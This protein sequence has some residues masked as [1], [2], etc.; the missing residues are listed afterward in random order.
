MLARANTLWGN[1]A[2]VQNEFDR[3]FRRGFADATR[4]YYPPVN[5]AENDDA[6]TIEAR[7]PGLAASEVA[8]ELEGRQLT[9]RGEHKRDNA[10]YGR[11]ERASGKFE[12][13]FTF[14]HEL[15]A[16]RVNAEAKDGILTIVLP[17]AEEAKARKISITAK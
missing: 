12:R 15:A 13:K 3:F 6:Y 5:I 17:K 7:V 9:I 4:G 1:F 8:V 11:E 10:E 14:K 16:D 2:D